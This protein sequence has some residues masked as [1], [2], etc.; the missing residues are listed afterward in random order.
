MIWPFGDKG[1][2]SKRSEDG[3]LA[4]V[5][6][7]NLYAAGRYLHAM[8]DDVK[9]S[10]KD[11]YIRFED[12]CLF[13]EL[14]HFLILYDQIIVDMSSV[15]REEAQEEY[16]ELGR[17]IETVN[18]AA[19]FSHIDGRVIAPKR[20]LWPV[21]NAVCRMIAKSS[22]DSEFVQFS[23]SIRIPWYYRDHAHFD[24]P[25]FQEAFKE[26]SIDLG[27]M[28]FALFLYRGIV[29]AGYANQYN[30]R[31]HVPMAYLASAG[32]LQALQPIID[33]RSMEFFRF[34]KAEYSNIVDLLGLPESGYDFSIFSL[35]ALHVSSLQRIIEQRS[36]MAALELVYELRGRT[37]ARQVRERWA[38]KLWGMNDSCAI[39]AQGSNWISGSTIHGNVNMVHA[40]ARN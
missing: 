7:A 38:E 34:P 11:Q 22:A 32:R 6:A 23:A 12:E 36:P 2:P 25:V 21:V 31:R 30:K 29:Y 5:D 14:M 15:E 20:E 33:K 19:G 35:E 13:F 1:T 4:L 9:W 18:V 37:Q 24:Y 16:G 17:V 28:P 40:S 8:H 39:G 3:A 27:L 26:Y 10:Y